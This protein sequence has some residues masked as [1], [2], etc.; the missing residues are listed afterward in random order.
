MNVRGACINSHGQKTAEA[1]AGQKTAEAMAST[2]H[3][4]FCRRLAASLWRQSCF[5]IHTVCA[6]CHVC[7]YEFQP[8]V[9]DVFTIHVSSFNSM[10]LASARSIKLNQKI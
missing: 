10:K 8:S 2:A 6:C 7:D 3:V 1:M 9:F 4:V 5:G